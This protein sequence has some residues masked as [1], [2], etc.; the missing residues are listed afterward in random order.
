MG[1]PRHP[2]EPWGDT[3]PRDA[4]AAGDD[5]ESGQSIR[6][7]VLGNRGV[8]CACPASPRQGVGVGRTGA[9]VETISS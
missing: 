5:L 3:R 2:T 4:Q 9:G 8:I 1:H 6:E 7:G